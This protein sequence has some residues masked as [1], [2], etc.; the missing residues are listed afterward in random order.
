MIMA[1]G[2]STGFWAVYVCTGLALV[3]LSTAKRDIFSQQDDLFY[4]HSNGVTVL[5]PEAPRGSWGVVNG[6]EY[7]KPTDK[8]L[9]YMTGTNAASVEGRPICTSGIGRMRGWL[10]SVSL[11]EHED[12]TS[13]DTS[14]VTDM[15]YMF[16]SNTDNQSIGYW[17]TSQVTNMARM[18]ERSN[19][20]Q[21]IGNWDT[22]KVTNMSGMFAYGYEF[23]QPI[24]NWNTSKVTDMHWMF[25]RSVFNQPIGDWDTSQVT[26][27]SSMFYRACSFNQDIGSWD[28]SKVT[29]MHW[30]FLCW[31]G[32]SFNHNLSAWIVNPNVK[33]CGDFALNASSWK[34]PK[35]SFESCNP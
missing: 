14:T 11:K 6:T 22:S 3:V 23:N 7:I 17:N 32:H 25:H 31:G 5:C 2:L 9:D 10:A 26:D 24:G 20:N 35:P 16:V 8:Q 18:F 33:Q 29:D 1:R 13:W 15:S 21:P 34:L 27:M 28:T 12:I 4:L 19:F 30:M